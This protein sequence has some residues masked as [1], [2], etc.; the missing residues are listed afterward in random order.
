MTMIYHVIIKHHHAALLPE[1]NKLRTYNHMPDSYQ[2]K[3]DKNEWFVTKKAQQETC[4][5]V[6]IF[7]AKMPI[8][9][10]GEVT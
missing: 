1:Y 7:H 8:I 6:S 4:L 2:I 5:N 10:I 9:Y 3:M